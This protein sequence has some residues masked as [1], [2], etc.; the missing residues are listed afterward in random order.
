MEAVVSLLGVKA[1]SVRGLVEAH[2]LL[3]L[4]T[5]DGV[6][7]FPVGQ[8]G[9]DGRLVPGVETVAG[10]LVEV[11]GSYMLLSWMNRRTIGLGGVSPAL[12]VLIVDLRLSHESVTE[13]PGGVA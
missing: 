13:C 11:L 4:R 1:E 9:A 3:M 12:M 6:C 10:L 5:T 7:L 2:R 8:F